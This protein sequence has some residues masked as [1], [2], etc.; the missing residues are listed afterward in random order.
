M[1]NFK[2]QKNIPNILQ[3]IDDGINPDSYKRDQIQLFID[4]NQKTKGRI[5]SLSLFKQE[6]K[7]QIEANYPDLA[8]Y[9]E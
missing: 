2:L 8:K 4:R 7:T 9:C 6:L 3:I 5:E 1:S